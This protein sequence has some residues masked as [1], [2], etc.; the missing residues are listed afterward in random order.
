MTSSCH[1]EKNMQPVAQF[2][3]PSI[4]VQAE[5]RKPAGQE[6]VSRNMKDPEAGKGYYCPVYYA[7]Q[8]T[9]TEPPYGDVTTGFYFG[10]MGRIKF[11]GEYETLNVRPSATL[12]SHACIR[13]ACKSCM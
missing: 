4:Q 11:R 12:H 2:D 8:F 1:R 6:E 13:A 9:S 7:M 3:V 10:H 5:V